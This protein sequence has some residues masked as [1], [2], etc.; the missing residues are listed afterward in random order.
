MN[1]Y[2]TDSHPLDIVAGLVTMVTLEEQLAAIRDLLPEEVYQQLAG[3]A[4]YADACTDAVEEWK[5]S[6]KTL[7]A[8]GS[9]KVC[10]TAVQA[11]LKDIE[12]FGAIEAMA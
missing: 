3:A 7:K 1:T 2:T 8:R 9:Y 10:P 5:A 6:A 11:L 12:D 4:A